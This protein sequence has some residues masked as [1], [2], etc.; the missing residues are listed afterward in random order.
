M[1]QTNT[2]PYFTEWKQTC[3]GTYVLGLE[4]GNAYPQGR[5]KEVDEGRLTILQPGDSKKMTLEVRVAS[6]A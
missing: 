2:L 1:W 3:E 4:P 5:A 6:P